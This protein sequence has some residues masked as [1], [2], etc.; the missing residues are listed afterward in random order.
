MC[1]CVGRALLG[2]VIKVKSKC[3]SGPHLVSRSLEEGLA[4]CPVGEVE[5]TEENLHEFF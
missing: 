1:A 5:E 4:F 3:Q 2:A